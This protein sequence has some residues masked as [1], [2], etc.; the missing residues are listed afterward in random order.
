M[1][2]RVAFCEGLHLE[3]GWV[4]NFTPLALGCERVIWKNSHSSAFSPI[5]HGCEILHL[6]L[7]GW[8]RV[9]YRFFNLFSF[10]FISHKSLYVIF[11]LRIKLNS[12]N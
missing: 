4:R 10:I 5:E 12:P 2:A 9:I 1:E 6:Q 7:R 3:Q 8:E 11:G